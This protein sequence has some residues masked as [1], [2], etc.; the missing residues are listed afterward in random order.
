MTQLDFP[1]QFKRQYAGPLD[2]DTVFATSAE[3]T[4]FLANPLCYAG[5]MVY[6][7]EQ[8]KPYWVNADKSGYA[9]AGTSGDVLNLMVHSD[10][11]DYT[12]QVLMVGPINNIGVDLPDEISA[13]TF[14]VRL[15]T[16]DTWS[17]QS[18]LTALQGWI[19]TYVTASTKWQIRLVATFNTGKYGEASIRLSFS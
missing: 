1:L 9:G 5:M 16:T 6:D 3:R 15:D 19:D 10:V 4:A 7:L 11:D 2:A 17:N 18:T 12:A 8:D 14:D 13:V